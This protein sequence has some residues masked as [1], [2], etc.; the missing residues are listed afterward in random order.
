[1]SFGHIHRLRHVRVDGPRVHGV[2]C[3]LAW[4]EFNAHAL[5]RGKKCRLA[6]AVSTKNRKVH[7]GRHRHHIHNCRSL[8]ALQHGNKG[9]HHFQGPVVV[10]LHVTF[11]QIRLVT[12]K[13]C[14]GCHTSV[15]DQQICIG[16]DLGG[17]SHLLLLGDVELK[18][19]HPNIRKVRKAPKLSSP[20]VDLLDA[21][22]E[23]FVHKGF[24]DA[25]VCAGNYGCL[26]LE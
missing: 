14:E 8:L 3:N 10:R 17:R 2:D 23:K 11:E 20:C 18:R 5:T 19:N 4:S 9:A 15:V 24:A 12:K 25:A 26:V 1:A 7:E 6:S 21:S 16:R 13:T 22:F